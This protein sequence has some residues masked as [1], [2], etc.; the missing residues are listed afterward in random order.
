MQQLPHIT[1]P[2]IGDRC[3]IEE[4]KSYI[5]AMWRTRWFLQDQIAI[6]QQ[7]KNTCPEL[8]LR[9][10]E[11]AEELKRADGVLTALKL[12]HKHEPK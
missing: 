12:N 6:K 9:E 4:L 11:L 10:A 3:Q 2:T 1:S 8:I 7:C 5:H